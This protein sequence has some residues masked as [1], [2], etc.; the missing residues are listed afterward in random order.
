MTANHPTQKAPAESRG[1][2]PWLRLAALTALLGVLM[3]VVAP[4]GLKL[5]GYRQMDRFIRETDLKATAIYYTDIEAF[6]RAETA[7]RDGL[8]FSP[9][10]RSDD[11]IQKSEPNANA[12]GRPVTGEK[13][14]CSSP[15]RHGFF[16]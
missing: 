1:L 7:L 16:P 5:P 15:R 11:G 2:S 6:A 3:F 10:D 13:S 4:L 12:H 9:L 8:R 14:S